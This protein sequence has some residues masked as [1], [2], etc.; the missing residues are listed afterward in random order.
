VG[1]AEDA[2]KTNQQ[3]LSD[4]WQAGICMFK[5]SLGSILLSA[6]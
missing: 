2:T 1:E 3:L 4:D 6:N 5:H